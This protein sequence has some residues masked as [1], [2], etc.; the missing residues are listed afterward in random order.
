[1]AI[2]ASLEDRPGTSKVLLELP[3]H[4]Y[5]QALEAHRKAARVRVVGTLG[6]HG[7]R[8]VLAHPEGFTELP[9]DDV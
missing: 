4:L 7:R 3:A 2:A 1:V 9:D 6:K 5:E 8:L